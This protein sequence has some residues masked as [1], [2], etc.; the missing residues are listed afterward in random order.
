MNLLA[1][2]HHLAGTLSPS[3]AL[4]S[5]RHVNGAPGPDEQGWAVT[6]TTAQPTSSTADLV[7]RLQQ[8]WDRTRTQPAD[9]QLSL[10]G[11]ES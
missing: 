2:H 4:I 6:T 11:S 5:E 1:K 10:L 9:P 7:R 8:A 3:S